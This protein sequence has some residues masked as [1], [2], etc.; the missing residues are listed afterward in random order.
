MKSGTL[1]PSSVCSSLTCLPLACSTLAS[2]A[3]FVR[4]RAS[5]AASGVAKA[6]SHSTLRSH[7]PPTMAHALYGR[8]RVSPSLGHVSHGFKGA[9]GVGW[10]K[11]VRNVYR[12]AQAHGALGRG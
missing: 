8:R 11:A 4:A 5:A 3:R 12:V 2:C 10:G 7:K 9:W 1:G 6:P